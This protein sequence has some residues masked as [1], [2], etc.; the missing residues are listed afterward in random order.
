MTD[1]TSRLTEKMQKAYLAI[2][3]EPQF[4]VLKGHGPALAMTQALAEVVFEEIEELRDRVEH[5]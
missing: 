2:K 1:K 4:L 5:P 3:D